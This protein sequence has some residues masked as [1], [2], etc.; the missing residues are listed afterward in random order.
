MKPLGAIYA[1][2]SG[3]P[4]VHHAFWSQ[5]LVEQLYMAPNGT[6]ASVS[7][8]RNLYRV[9]LPDQNYMIYLI[10]YIGNMRQDELQCFLRFVM[11][12]SVKIAKPIKVDFNGLQGGL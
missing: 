6:P 12:S 10:R 8:Y 3:V 7:Y 9:T 1:L 2:H 11:G 5:F 4:A